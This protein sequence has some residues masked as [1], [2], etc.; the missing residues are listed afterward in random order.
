MP[1][2]VERK[3]KKLAG[4]DIID[5]LSLKRDTNFRPIKTEHRGV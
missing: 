2:H 5:V 4:T 3:I 1:A